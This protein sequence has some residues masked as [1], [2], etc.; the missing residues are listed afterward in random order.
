MM[1]FFLYNYTYNEIKYNKEQNVLQK[2]TPY[3]LEINAIR[4]LHCDFPKYLL[5]DY[6][7]YKRHTIREHLYKLLLLTVLQHLL[8]S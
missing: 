1:P 5:K 3:I 4:M 2:K 8:S 6:G 7:F